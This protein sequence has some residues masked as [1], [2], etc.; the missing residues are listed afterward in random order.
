MSVSVLNT[1]LFDDE[2]WFDESLSDASKLWNFITAQPSY[3]Q[4]AIILSEFD[5]I[6]PNI[7][8]SKALS[9]VIFS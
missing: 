6:I 3:L 2:Y 9:S 8:E 7:F 5:M 1:K 4:K